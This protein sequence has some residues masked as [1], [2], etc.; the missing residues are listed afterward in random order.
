[1]RCVMIGALVGLA[2]GGCSPDLR[3]FDQFPVDV[4][5]SAGPL[6]VAVSDTQRP[7]PSI[8]AI[9]TLSPITVLDS[10]DPGN[11]LPNPVQRLTDLTLYATTSSTPGTVPR[12]RFV[13]LTVFDLHPC[14]EARPDQYCQVGSP[15][16]PREITAIL[17][18]DALRERAVRFDFSTSSLTFFPDI[19]GS[20]EARGR[21]C[22]AVFGSPFSGG[23]TLLIGG[24]EVSFTGT[25]IALG[26]CLAF[27]PE[28]LVEKDRGVDVRMVLSTGLG[29]SVI[30]E[31]A[32]QR[33]R[34]FC[35][36]HACVDPGATDGLPT[37]Q[38]LLPSGPVDVHL[39]TV[40]DIAL[41]S[42]G[43]DDRGPCKELHANH[44]MTRDAC[45]DPNEA[46]NCPCNDNNTFCTT[47]SAVELRQSFQ[48]AIVPDST[49]VLQA[50]RAELR[51][52][53]PEVD[54][55]L[56]INALANVGLDVDY[57]N[58][59]LVARCT[60]EDPL[61]CLARPEIRRSDTHSTIAD[62]CPDVQ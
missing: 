51:P 53:L 58:N 55:I 26:A 33:Y 39:A 50:L 41:V 35:Q 22:E 42:E 12:S 8:A 49:P 10:F 43:A 27:D 40:E 59:R 29:L 16:D 15:S 18:A 7:T 28:S 2:A 5:M 57:P 34:T 45:N 30:G 47:G 38:I 20:A 4:D 17:G 21:A 13:D 62:N 61:V 48:V 54:G 52:D 23:G 56:G 9:D 37:G 25:R 14:A 31:G 3:T 60:V 46:A 36:T 6:L 44:L 32:Y 11:G 19:A 1:M 24:G